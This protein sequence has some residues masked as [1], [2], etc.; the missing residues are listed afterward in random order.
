MHLLEKNRR[1]MLQYDLDSKP[2]FG[3]VQI[4]LPNFIHQ[5]AQIL[6]FLEFFE[7][8]LKDEESV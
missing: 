8:Y 2:L 5:K 6:L 1:G 4:L 7:I 3:V